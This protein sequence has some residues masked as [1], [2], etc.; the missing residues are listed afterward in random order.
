MKKCQLIVYCSFLV[1][2]L[3][4]TGCSK[5]EDP[6]LLAAAEEVGVIT[7]IFE[8]KE[9]RSYALGLANQTY[10]VSIE[11][12][13]DNATTS[14]SLTYF[15]GG[16]IPETLRTYVTLKLEGS[17]SQMIKVQSIKCGALGYYDDR[18]N[19]EDVKQITEDSKNPDK[20]IYMQAFSTY[21]DKGTVFIIGENIY[22]LYLAKADPLLYLLK[23][24]YET[25]THKFIFIL[26]KIENAL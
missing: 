17:V 26:T 6:R 24:P 19:I 15:V 22:K 10:S 13:E 11:K 14:C 5:D 4:W 20:D 21:F 18:S 25:V 8:V 12:I 3:L 7:D 16:V 23:N 2:S 9:G 1:S